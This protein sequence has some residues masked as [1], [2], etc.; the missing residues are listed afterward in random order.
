MI[1]ACGGRGPVH[2]AG[3]RPSTIFDLIAYLG[4]GVA[5]GW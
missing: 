1:R 3:L 2:E 4:T 5:R